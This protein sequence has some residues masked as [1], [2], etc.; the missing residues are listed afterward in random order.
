MLTK[1][2]NTLFWLSYI[3][4]RLLG[5][6]IFMLLLQEVELFEFNSTDLLLTAGK[7]L[8]ISG[9]VWLTISGVKRKKLAASLG[10]NQYVL[11]VL[12]SGIISDFL[13][14]IYDVLISG[15]NS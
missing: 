12:L 9:V 5:V 13:W 8:L 6:S 7:S 14:V 4:Q 10:L 15:M 2:K 1:M 11:Y 3:L